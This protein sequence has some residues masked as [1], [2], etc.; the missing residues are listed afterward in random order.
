MLEEAIHILHILLADDDDGDRRQITRA[1]RQAGM[2]V[3]CT[4]TSSIKEALEACEKIAFS[5]AIVDFLLP[6]ENGLTGITA[7]HNRLPGMAIVMVT[8]HGDEATAT[9]AM[10]RGASDYMS[11][12]SITAESIRRIVENAVDKASLLK[13]MLQ[14]RSDLEVFNRLLVHD[15]KAPI[16]TALGFAGLIEEMVQEN[17]EPAEIAMY[18]RKIV[19]NL[20][21]L[22][23][24]IDTLHR[25]ASE[26]EPVALM[27]IEMNKVI[28]DTLSN[29]ESQ[30]KERGAQITHGDLPA[31]LGTPQ[32]TQ[33]MQNLIGN[34]LKYCDA[35]VP[36]VDVTAER[37]DGNFWLISVK[38]NGIGI[39]EENYEQVF[40]PF[41][42]LH[43]DSK[44]AGTGLG[45]ATCK[46]I[47]ERHGG[48]ISCFSEIGSGT[49]F[50]FTL[51]DAVEE[52]GES[53]ATLRRGP[54]VLLVE[55]NKDSQTLIVKLLKNW[56]YDCDVAANGSHA[57]SM[58]L[59]CEYP[60]VLMDCEM[61]E[62]DGF[63]ATSEIRQREGQSRRTRIVAL[64]AHTLPVDRE[65]CFA[66]GMDD[67]LSKPVNRELLL[68]TIK[69]WRSVLTSLSVR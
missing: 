19:S 38:D 54:K 17:S 5:C 10:K 59:T 63:Q 51:R 40:E 48:T 39:A 53:R 20:E 4:E 28:S 57:L 69:S 35:E 45:L 52:S 42:R 9:E 64:T 34:A 58:M 26:E 44:Y 55:D 23:L 33:L 11:K 29:L 50:S 46:R 30:I 61:P 12:T 1:L 25:Y 47:V 36:R 24:L 14:Q 66:A 7:L 43:G 27:R 16:N 65:R 56:G 6:G 18:C 67:Y 31:V 8:G 15:V 13:A 68:R 2:P 3:I 32:L 21:R 37:V 49:T 22:C 62:M 60:L 41:K